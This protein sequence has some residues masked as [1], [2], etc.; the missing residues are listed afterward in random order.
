MIF[1]TLELLHLVDLHRVILFIS[2]TEQ[3]FVNISK[4][5]KATLNEAT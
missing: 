4:V 1:D 3:T 5:S 2:Y